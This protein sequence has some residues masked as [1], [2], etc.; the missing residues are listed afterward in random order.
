MKSI[1]I[2]DILH[3]RIRLLS[4]ITGKKIYELIKEAIEYLEN[5]YKE[6]EK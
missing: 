6:K 1:G 3:K 5:K 2:D 4:V